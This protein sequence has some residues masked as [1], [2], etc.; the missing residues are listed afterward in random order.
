MLY[1]PVG[2]NPIVN[3]KICFLIFSNFFLDS[4]LMDAL[5]E[6]VHTQTNSSSIKKWLNYYDQYESELKKTIEE[7]SPNKKRSKEDSDSNDENQQKPKAKKKQK[8]LTPKLF[9]NK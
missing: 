6:I 9:I 2:K 4:E 1:Y 3:S 5:V 8:P 7:A